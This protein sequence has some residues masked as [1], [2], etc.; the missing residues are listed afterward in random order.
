[1][2]YPQ[3]GRTANQLITLSYLGLFD[4]PMPA[5]TGLPAFPD[6]HDM[7][8]SIDQRARAYVH[9]NCSMCHRPGGPGLG[10]QDFRYQVSGQ[11]MNIYDVA[12]TQDDFGIEG[13]K[14]YAPGSPEHSVI[15][16]RTH[17]LSQGRMPPLAS[18][19]VDDLGTMILDDWIRSGLGFGI[20]DSD[21]DVL[22]DNLDNCPYHKNLDQR[23]SDGDRH[24]NA[25]DGD[26]NNDNV[27]NVLDFGLFK[28]RFGSDDADADLN[29][30]GV[31]NVLD[32][33]RFKLLFGKAPGVP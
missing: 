27:V 1:M 16:Y 31:V 21:G 10:P 12:P 13:A 14:L 7:S 26:L 30:D 18:G 32:L 8:K 11:E 33:G 5:P 6:P 15:S 9:A 24:G 29:G 20:A 17:T 25:C 19:V 22:A 23:D 3:T 4:T 2:Y 28:K